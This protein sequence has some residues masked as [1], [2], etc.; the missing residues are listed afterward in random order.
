M[1]RHFGRG[2]VLRMTNVDSFL[3]DYA[4]LEPFARVVGRDPRTVRRWMEGAQRAALHAHGQSYLDPYP[5]REVLAS[6]ADAKAKPKTRKTGPLCP[7]VGVMP[8]P[9]MKP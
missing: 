2:T 8:W 1:H 3:D 5:D 7:G 6:V 4:D 9:I